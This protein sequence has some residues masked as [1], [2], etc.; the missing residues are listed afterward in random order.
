MRAAIATAAGSS[1]KANE[2]WAGV[3]PT[4]AVVLD[5]LSSAPGSESP[6]RHGTPWFVQRLGGRILMLAGESDVDLRDALA[7][8]IRDVAALHPE[9]DAC[10]DGAPS[11]TVAAFRASSTDTLDYL[12]LADARITIETSQGLQV[13][14]D[15]RVDQFAKDAQTAALA[16]PIGSAAQRQAVADL[17]ETQKPLRNRPDGY[18]VAAGE[19]VAAEHAVT[20]SVPRESVLQAVLLSDGASRVVDVFGQLTWSEALAVIRDDGPQE[21][22]RR[23][24]AFEATDPEGRRW[25]RYKTGDDATIVYATWDRGTA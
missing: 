16:Q 23:V 12:V 9:C 6:C 4:V 22:I 24:R 21:L 1:S 15:E 8:A 18:W 11:A 10:A 13:V 25:P 7:G 5:G 17:I 19:P 14:T 3:A 2:D 20:G